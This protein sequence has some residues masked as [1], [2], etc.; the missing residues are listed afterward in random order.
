M[1]TQKRE[2]L[3]ELP[4]S[5]LNYHDGVGLVTAYTA[6][7]MRAYGR[8]CR[9]G[10]EDAIELLSRLDDLSE[11]L[12]TEVEKVGVGT[13]ADAARDVHDAAAMIRRLSPQAGGSD[14]NR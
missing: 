13:G 12:A 3:P 4:E 8:L 11:C 10:R 9:A 5:N 1:N 7:Q 14:G 6:D 2:E